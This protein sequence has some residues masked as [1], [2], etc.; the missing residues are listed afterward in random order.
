MDSP[1]SNRIA[2]DLNPFY[3]RL[4][5]TSEQTSSPSQRPFHRACYDP[6][7]RQPVTSLIRASS[8]CHIR[9]FPLNGCVEMIVC[10]CSLSSRTPGFPP[11]SP[12]I[13]TAEQRDRSSR[14]QSFSICLSP[15][16]LAK[17]ASAG[18]LASLK[19]NSAVPMPECRAFLPPADPETLCIL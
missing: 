13:P 6:Q 4:H 15:P 3:G 9:Q 7:A 10:E 14:Y 11:D 18:T 19:I 17:K 1:C 8:S 12:T 2:K 16:L 5:G